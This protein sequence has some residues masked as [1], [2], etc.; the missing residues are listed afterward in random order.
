[1]NRIS[2]IRA[3][4]RRGVA[5]LSVALLLPVWA[6]AAEMTVGQAIHHDTSP[7]L[8]EM[9]M[10]AAAPGGE[11][12]VIPI[13]KRDEYGRFPDLAEPDAQPLTDADIEVTADWFSAVTLEVRK[14]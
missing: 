9:A 3:A 6:Q 13:M 1:M 5:V 2:P 10:P 7:P 14:P 11:N 4:A 8:S 12:K